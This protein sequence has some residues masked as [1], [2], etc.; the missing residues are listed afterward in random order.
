MGFL[1]NLMDHHGREEFRKQTRPM[2]MKL[3]PSTIGMCQRKI[4]FDML[5]VPKEQPGS[6]LMRIFDNGHSLHHRYEKLFKEMGI[7]VKDEMKLEADN[8]S[9]HTDAWIRVF[10]MESPQGQDYLVELKSAFSKS[11]EWM[12]KN[13][14]PKNE[15][16]DQLTFY[17]HLVRKQ[18][19]PIDKGIILVENKDTQEIWEF[20]MAYDPV[21]G[22]RLEEKANWCISLAQARTVPPIPPK[23]TPSYYKCG[24]CDYNIYCHAGSRKNNGDERYPIPF[25]FGSKAYAETVQ[26]IDAIQNNQPI[27][28]VIVGDTNGELATEVAASNQVPAA[29]GPQELVAAYIQKNNSKGWD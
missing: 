16:R 25:R 18:G 12:Q 6:R 1:E 14:K 2:R 3:H 27:P 24:M 20:E 9:G 13:N 19:I 26:V 10:S 11:F 21:L 4:V 29:V 8:I 22:H 15:H 17:L 28:D 5:M 7:L 23:H